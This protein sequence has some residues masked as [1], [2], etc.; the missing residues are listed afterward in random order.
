M[1]IRTRTMLD[2]STRNLA[3]MLAEGSSQGVLD[4]KRAETDY[5]LG[6]PRRPQ[7]DAAAVRDADP[8]R[9][10]LAGV[11]VSPASCAKGRAPQGSAFCCILVVLRV[12][13]PLLFRPARTGK[14]CPL[15]PQPVTVYITTIMTMPV[16]MLSELTW[17]AWAPS[18]PA[19]LVSSGAMLATG[20]MSSTQMAWR[21]SAG[22]GT[23]K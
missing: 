19:F 10:D 15:P 2:K 11:C 18:P 20:A 17:A 9:T 6:Q 14:G 12:I 1:G 23:R 22:S 7:T 21:M 5:P 3:T 8:R 4:C 13:R 16:R